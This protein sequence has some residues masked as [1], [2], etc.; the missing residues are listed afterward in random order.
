MVTTRLG[1]QH[2]MPFRHL[3]SPI[4]FAQSRIPRPKWLNNVS[5]IHENNMNIG[6]T[7]PESIRFSHWRHEEWHD[8]GEAVSRL[9]EKPSKVVFSGKNSQGLDMEGTSS[10]FQSQYPDTIWKFITSLFQNGSG[11]LSEPPHCVDI[12][13]CSPG[14]AGVELARR[15]FRVTGI[16][17]DAKILKKTFDFAISKSAPIE[18]VPATVEKAIIADQSA[19]LVSIFCG[20][21]RL[22]LP[23][24]LEE[25]WRILK[26]NGY[27]IAVWNDR[28]LS[29]PM[30]KEL[31]NILERHMHTYNRFQNQHL[32]EDWCIKLEETNNFKVIGYLVEENPVRIPS[33]AAFLDTIDLSAEVRGLRGEAKK[34]FHADVSELFKS[35]FGQSGFLWPMET[36]LYILKR[37]DG[38]KKKGRL[39]HE[40]IFSA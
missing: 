15:G 34:R 33:S 39:H 28:D 26:P 9:A 12:A 25:C 21:D 11:P 22:N 14:L 30:V 3:K 24:A 8:S 37:L 35:R 6:E 1:D 38:A 27:M 18:L 36:K 17:A 20:L 10:L 5:G 4:R 31:E 19:D 29:S 40:T 7:L 32:L 2:F 16:E 13:V 23:E